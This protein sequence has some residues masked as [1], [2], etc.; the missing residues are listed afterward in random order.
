METRKPREEKIFAGK[1]SR[2][3]NREIF[4]DIRAGRVELNKRYEFCEMMMHAENSSSN[5]KS[6]AH[7][8]FLE[9]FGDEEFVQERRELA[10]FMVD[11]INRIASPNNAVLYQIP[12]YYCEF[13]SSFVD[14]IGDSSNSL[15]LEPA[16]WGKDAK[17]MAR[18]VDLLVNS[19]ARK[20]AEKVRQ[21]QYDAGSPI[22]TPEELQFMSE[23]KASVIRSLVPYLEEVLA[24][25]VGEP[26]SDRDRKEKNWQVFNIKALLARNFPG[27]WEAD[28]R[29]A[30]ESSQMPG[31]VSM[32][33]QNLRQRIEDLLQT[34]QR[35]LGDF[36]KMSD[37]SVG[38]EETLKE[39][40][41]RNSVLETQL[42]QA[43]Q[44]VDAAKVNFQ[45][46][47]KRVGRQKEE[48]IPA[49]RVFALIAA[50]EEK[51]ARK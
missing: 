12:I 42:V 13:V 6:L 10:D 27:I 51:L 24:R 38:V 25:F 31:L 8:I 46:A 29:L 11:Y 37:H 30:V 23:D 7:L 43:R 49:D 50:L 21:V 18:C 28:A 16:A 34:G 35:L 19:R 41:D 45:L 40:V 48:V 22:L 2:P 1:L 3:L 44:S 33:R 5:I 47:V 36:K 17:R 15:M 20:R 32:E 26:S 39:E 14:L 4:D 9:S